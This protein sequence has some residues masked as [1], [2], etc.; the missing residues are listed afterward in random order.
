VT[1]DTKAEAAGGASR[2]VPDLPPA[3]GG[4]WSA[5]HRAL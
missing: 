5:S 3:D 2:P 4:L 1:A